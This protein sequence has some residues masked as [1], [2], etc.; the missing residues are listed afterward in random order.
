MKKRINE[1]IIFKTEKNI[2]GW[3]NLA[4]PEKLL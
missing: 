2:I 3:G 1:Y 4:S